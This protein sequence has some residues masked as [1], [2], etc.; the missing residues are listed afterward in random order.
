MNIIIKPSDIVKRCLWD[1]YVYYIV[2]SDKEA[3]NLLKED[4]EFEISEREALIIG[5]LKVIET[6]NLI[7][8][9]NTYIVEI[10]ANKS[11]KDKE[12]GILVRK[13]ILDT[14]IE[15]Y[16]DNFPEHWDC[17]LYW[18]KCINDLKVYIEDIKVSICNLHVYVITDKNIT[19][20]LYLTNSVKKLLKFNY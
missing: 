13:K 11:I 18:K 14:A 17:S 19:S 3:Q 16:M 5:L 15:T 1:S 10:L 8:K 12:N 4:L 6:D 7:H 2:G 9:F 20:E